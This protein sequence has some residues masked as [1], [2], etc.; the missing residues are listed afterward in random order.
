MTHALD[1]A[2]WPPLAPVTLERH[3]VRLRPLQEADAPALVEAARDGELWKLGY[4]MIGSPQT[5]AAWVAQALAA[6][7]Q[8]RVLPFVVEHLPTGRLIGSTRFLNIELAHRRLEIG[9]T[10]YAGSWQR[11]AVNTTC[12]LLLLGHAFDTL[13][14]IAVEFRTDERNARSRQAILALGARHDGV[15]R[16]HLI[17]PDGWMRNTYVFSILRGEWPAVRE[18]LD[19]R[20]ARH[21]AAAA[22]PG[23]VET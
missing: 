13:G 3:P 9:N 14:A 6:Q 7:S 20:L 1:P 17:M 19:E 21:A 5:M 8:H 2:P 4:T 16:R 10:W 12:K 18:R 22:A 23:P 15:L 11:S